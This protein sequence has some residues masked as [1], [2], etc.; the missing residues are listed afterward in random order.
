MRSK[1]HCEIEDAP[2][3]WNILSDEDKSEYGRLRQTILPLNYRTSKKQI[4]NKFQV[5]VKKINEY[6][7]RAEDDQWKR[8]LVCGLL[9]LADRSA[10]LCTRQLCKLIGRCK[11]SVNSGFQAIGLVNVPITTEYA[12][13]LM[14][15]FPFMIDNCTEMRQWTFRAPMNQPIHTNNINNS[16]GVG[17][18]NS[19]KADANLIENEKIVKEEIENEELPIKQTDIVLD[20][21]DDIPG[22]EFEEMYYLF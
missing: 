18:N 22:L 5:I 9:W 14:K 8:S 17:I 21:Y 3:Y 1:H 15:A 12:S 11:S 13:A 4:R 6:I 10:A 20:E 2:I 19:N 16:K 7:Y